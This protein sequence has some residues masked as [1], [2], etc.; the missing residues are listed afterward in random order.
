[1]SNLKSPFGQPPYLDCF[2]GDPKSLHLYWVLL[3]IQIS[4]ECHP[5]PTGRL[6]L[7]TFAGVKSGLN[8]LRFVLNRVDAP[9]SHVAVR[10]ALTRDPYD[11]ESTM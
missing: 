11:A 5:G 1:M 9:G 3:R 6:Q 10:A 8:N 4:I 7:L 2:L